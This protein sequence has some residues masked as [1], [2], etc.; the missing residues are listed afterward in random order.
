MCA[1]Q[2]HSNTVV[3][4]VREQVVVIETR[5]PG[6]CSSIV[7]SFRERDLDSK[8]LLS[9]TKTARQSKSEMS[10]FC[11][12]VTKTSH[13][14]VYYKSISMIIIIENALPKQMTD[15]GN[16]CFTIPSREEGNFRTRGTQGQQREKTYLMIR[17]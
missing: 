17:Y 7:Y 5:G 8:S 11:S 9:E 10:N 14:T 3:G 13:G 12:V 16:S 15:N 1:A 4:I 6:C 2:K